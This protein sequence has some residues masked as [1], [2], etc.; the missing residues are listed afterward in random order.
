MIKGLIGNKGRLLL[1]IFTVVIYMLSVRGVYADDGLINSDNTEQ[2]ITEDNEDNTEVVS[3]VE[4]GEEVEPSE[5]AEVDADVENTEDAAPAEGAEEAAPTEGTE[6]GAPEENTEEA[7]PEEGNEE[8]LPEE[9]TEEA[10]PEENGEEASQILVDDEPSMALFAGSSASQYADVMRVWGDYRYDTAK[11]I[12]E[13]IKT[14]LNV[15]KFKNIIVATGKTFPDALSGSYLAYKLSAPILLVDDSR[16]DIVKYVKDNLANN[17][18]IYILGGKDVVSKKVEDGFS[19]LNVQRVEG[20]TR[21]DTNLEILKLAQ[22][23]KSSEML[24]STGTNFMDALSASAVPKPLMLVNETL[25]WNQ[26]KYLDSITDNKSV[27]FYI[28]GGPNVVSKNL[29]NEI[30]EYGKTERVY[31][32]TRYDT[33]VEVAKQFFPSTVNTVF[34]TTGTN[35]PDGVA[36]GIYAMLKKAPIILTN[37]DSVAFAYN[38]MVDVKAKNRIILGGESVLNSGVAEK[39]SE[40]GIV[41]IGTYNYYVKSNGKIA[42]GET[43]NVDGAKYTA[44]NSGVLSGSRAKPAWGIDVSAWNGKIDWTK[45]KKAGVDFAIIRVGGRFAGSGNIYSDLK[46]KENLAGAIAAGIKVGVYFFSQAVTEAEAIQEA[47]YTL[48]AINGFNVELP[49]VIDTE[50]F[51]GTSRHDRISAT[52]RTK[53]VKAFMDYVESQGY[54]SMLYAG[55]FWLRDNLIESELTKYDKWIPQYYKECQY[56]GDYVA[57]QYSSTGRVNGIDGDVDMNYWYGIL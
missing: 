36:G 28:I 18:T 3:D 6:E 32:Q 48:N 27:K 17:G 19:G 26:R 49:V 9:N 35:F 53:V 37:N 21:F 41:R 4:A 45:V 31:G 30:A 12:A 10:L 40:E 46:A 20:Q 42:A 11:E 47:K 50:Y 8:A 43:I 39:V 22:A 24:V 33:S 5:N 51:D 44:L 2:E 54:K 23:D 52:T 14:E 56:W 13:K 34:L 29:A 16:M 55:M 25:Y 7:Y 15:K 1:I 38:Y 57:W